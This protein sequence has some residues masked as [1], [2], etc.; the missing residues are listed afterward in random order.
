MWFLVT[1]NAWRF[2][3]VVL[4]TSNFL[5]CCPK[6]THGE[7]MCLIWSAL[8][9]SALEEGAQHCWV[10]HS[11]SPKMQW[12]LAAQLCPC[13]PYLSGLGNSELVWG[14]REDHPS[15]Q[16]GLVKF[17]VGSS[18]CRDCNL[19]IAQASACLVPV[20]WLCRVG[21]A[22][23]WIPG[24]GAAGSEALSAVSVLD[25]VLFV[26]SR[27]KRL[28]W[29]SEECQ[30]CRQLSSCAS[31]SA[32]VQGQLLPLPCLWLLLFTT[33]RSGNL[34]GVKRKLVGSQNEYST[35]P[36]RSKGLMALLLLL[37]PMCCQTSDVRLGSDKW[38]LGWTKICAL[39]S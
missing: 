34:S 37:C 18:E 1:A 36:G 13:S 12:T 32:G 24:T 27:A 19:L 38:L 3:D 28:F 2:S 30:A 15:M 5:P 17:A 14:C 35:V 16:M 4:E 22:Q 39:F 7:G 29:L 10:L 33:A 11:S 23:Q 9:L 8:C 20:A 25:L 31:I 21:G 6:A 26:G